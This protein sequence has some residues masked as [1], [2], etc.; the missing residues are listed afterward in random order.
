MIVYLH[1]CALNLKNDG[2]KF[3]IKKT[4]LL[5]VVCSHSAPLNASI[6]FCATVIDFRKLNILPSAR[7]VIG[8]NILQPHIK[9]LPVKRFN[10]SLG[11]SWASIIGAL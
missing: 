3:R 1:M 10:I 4:F 7:S 2:V 11:S 8:Y 5:Q 6:V 9:V